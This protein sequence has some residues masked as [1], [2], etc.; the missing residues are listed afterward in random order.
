[1]KEFGGKA[2][3]DYHEYRSAKVPFRLPSLRYPV[4]M[5]WRD[6]FERA[7]SLYK[8]IVVREQQNQ[9]LVKSPKSVLRHQYIA[10]LC[11]TFDRFADLLLYSSLFGGEYLFQN[12][13]WWYNEFK[14]AKVVNISDLS[15]FL[16]E[17]TGRRL[18]KR[19]STSGMNVTINPSE[20]S[21][22]VLN[23]W[24][25]RDYSIID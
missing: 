17:L 14:P 24:A 22:K 25:A 3:G 1:M 18:E 19:H 13:L 2:I 5:V 7:I 11:P 4:F 21:L 23:E 20:D 15:D 12:Q 6:P 9:R 10:N 16:E 8:D